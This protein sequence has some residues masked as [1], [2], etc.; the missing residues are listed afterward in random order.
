MTDEKFESLWSKWSS[1]WYEHASCVIDERAVPV[2]NLCTIDFTSS[3]KLH[4]NYETIKNVVKDCYFKE[5]SEKK[6]NRY[7]RAAVIAY[8][9]IVT[10]PIRCE[11]ND[12]KFDPLFLKQRLAL[13]VALGSILQDYSQE[14]VENLLLN[15]KVIFDFDNIGLSRDDKNDSFLLSIY[16]DLFYAEIYEN[17]NVLTFA[18]LLLVLVERASLLSQIVPIDEKDN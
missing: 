10:N 4:K 13:Y 18:N 14:D 7:K 12:L 9:I 1:L 6:L 3:L 15:K 8:T 2:R 17:F 16:K 5:P 11:A